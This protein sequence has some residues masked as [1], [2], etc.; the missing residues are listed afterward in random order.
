MTPHNPLHIF[1]LD[2]D[3]SFIF[4]L[5]NFLY[6]ITPTL[7]IYRHS[8]DPQ[9][10]FD[11]MTQSKAKGE[12]PILVL[13]PGPKSPSDVP[14]MMALLKLTH[15]TFPILGICLGH[16]AIIE[17]YGGTVGACPQIMHG[18]KSVATLSNHPVY[19]GLGDSLVVARYHSLTGLTIPDTLTITAQTT[20][21][22]MGVA[23]DNNTVIGFQFHPESILTVQGETLLTN[24]FHYFT[25]N[26]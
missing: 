21:A 17:H 25:N 22:V 20:D 7:S 19:K 3:D 13:S 5:V 2:N 8:T 18:K 12:M 1:V 15:G 23:D 9:F 10:I 24:T 16:Q 14:N 11:A 26:Q 4:N 6:T